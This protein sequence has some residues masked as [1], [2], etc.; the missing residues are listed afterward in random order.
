[1]E[2]DKIL[3]ESLIV[4]NFKCFSQEVSIGPFKNLTGVLG[5]NGV[6]KSTVFEALEFVLGKD[7]VIK[8]QVYK[9]DNF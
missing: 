5:P 8:G 6:G 3:L 4:D 7:L 9:Y 1:M 2:I